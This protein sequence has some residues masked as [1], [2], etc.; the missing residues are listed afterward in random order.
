LCGLQGITSIE[1]LDAHIKGKKHQAAMQP[2]PPPQPVVKLPEPLHP[3]NYTLS[4]QQQL[5][6]L[7]QRQQALAAQQQPLLSQQRQAPGLQRPPGLNN[8]IG[9]PIG[10]IG[11]SKPMQPIS[12][13]GQPSPIGQPSPKDQSSPFFDQFSQAHQPLHMP[14]TFQPFMPAFQPPSHQ[15]FQPMQPPSHQ[16]NSL[17]HSFQGF[18]PFQPQQQQSQDQWP[19]APSPMGTPWDPRGGLPSAPAQPKLQSQVG[20]GFQSIEQILQHLNLMEWLPLFQRECVDHEI[21]MM[22]TDD[23]L[24]EMQLPADDRSK[25]LHFIHGNP[26]PLRMGAGF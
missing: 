25:L 6:Q 8:P 18:Q 5:E 16:F 20:Y 3:P 23:H 17:Q 24:A 9:M 12:I 1:Q 15:S 11:Q 14:Q 19:S 10:S 22:L 4:K 26:A 7:Q 2:T 13:L 21:L